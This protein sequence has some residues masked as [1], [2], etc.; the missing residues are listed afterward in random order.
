MK[1]ILRLILLLFPVFAFVIEYQP[2]FGNVYEFNLLSRYSYS[3]FSSVDSAFPPLAETSHDHLFY[4]DL[5]FSPSS[6]L[7]IDT[8]IEFTETPRQSF[9]FRSFALQGRYLF[10]DDNIGDKV[11]LALGGNIRYTSSISLKDISCPYYANCDFEGTVAIGKEF[12]KEDFWRVRIWGTGGIGIGNRGSPF[13]LGI[14]ALEGNIHEVNKWSIFAIGTHGYGRKTVIDID[15]FYGYANIR[16]KNVDIAG[17]YGHR[18]GVWGTLSF[19][20]RRRVY[21]KCCPEGVNSF[22]I[23]YLLPF[24]F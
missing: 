16:E 17:R 21:A 13:F 20:Y 19:E 7:S 14:V 2:W 22:A 8:D 24:S 1:F 4:F 11:S 18:F 9:G 23:N 15:D 3:Y 5:E 12:Y 6:T 10:F